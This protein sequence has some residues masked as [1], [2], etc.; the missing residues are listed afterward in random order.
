MS[1]TTIFLIVLAFVLYALFS[2]GY[3]TEHRIGRYLPLALW[4]LALIVG[5]AGLSALVEF[6]TP[7][8]PT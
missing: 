4:I 2:Y 6:C 7:S 1:T 3:D 5:L 8:S